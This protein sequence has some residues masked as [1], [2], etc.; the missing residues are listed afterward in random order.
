MTIARHL[1][2][3]GKALD[4]R[5]PLHFL[6]IGKNAGTQIKHIGDQITRGSQRYRFVRHPHRRTLDD[7]PAGQKYFFSIR[8]PI[9]RFKSGFYSRKR[10]GQPRIYS[11]WTAE[12]ALAFQHFEHANELAEALYEDSERGRLA[13]SAM[14]S[15]SH[16]A[17]HQVGWLGEHGFFLETRPPVHIIRQERFDEDLAGL[18][19]RLELDIEVSL[20][21][22]PKIVH[23][24]D[25]QRTPPLSALAVGHL[26]VWYSADFVLYRLCERWLEGR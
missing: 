26:R 12:E 10:K 5:E 11:E 22:D 17:R 13:Y 21:P 9:T 3:L 16:V 18:L 14:R 8:D 23:R 19:R 25:Y 20:S 15:I 1:R 2:R 24:N 6:H 7:V 4:F